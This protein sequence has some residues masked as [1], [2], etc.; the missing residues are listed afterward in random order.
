MNKVK[1]TREN[2]VTFFNYKGIEID[3]NTWEC[4]GCSMY[5]GNITDDDYCNIVKELYA[6]LVQTFGE[7]K[8]ANYIKELSKD[9]H[10]KEFENIDIVRWE[11][12]E[13][14]FLNY[15]GKYYEDM[16]DEEYLKVCGEN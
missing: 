4:A 10:S 3:T 13:K 7:E 15:G 12:E 8:I 5:C 11:E 2:G 16:T 1:I 6:S 14:L 9:T